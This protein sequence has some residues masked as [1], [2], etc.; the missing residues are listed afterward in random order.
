MIPQ[1]LMD[2]C[3]QLMKAILPI[4]NT[5]AFFNDPVTRDMS[6]MLL[7]GVAAALAWVEVSAVASVAISLGLH[8]TAVGVHLR[9]L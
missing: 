7:R 4:T 9:C 8:C 1:A 2:F 3:W 6:Q 5:V